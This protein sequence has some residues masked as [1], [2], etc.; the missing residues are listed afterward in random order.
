ML[1]KKLIYDIYLLFHDK[2]VL[3]PMYIIHII[4]SLYLIAKNVIKIFYTGNSVFI[5]HFY[6]VE[7]SHGL[8][9][10]KL[11]FIELRAYE[12]FCSTS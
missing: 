3:S 6:S 5:N 2:Y 9:L 8:S 12:E 11:R 4:F 1:K 7:L 10:L